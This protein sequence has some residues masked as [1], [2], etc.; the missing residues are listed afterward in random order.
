MFAA[1]VKTRFL[2]MYAAMFKGSRISKK[3]GPIFKILIALFAAYCIGALLF[4]LGMLFYGL[5]NPLCSAG[6][7][8]LYFTIE[9]IFCFALCFIG[10]VYATQ[11][12]IYNARD[13]ELL[14]S[15]PVPPAYIL[16]SRM[17]LL[18]ALNFIYGSLVAIPAGVVYIMQFGATVIGVLFYVLAFILLQFMA[19][20][21]S[22]LIGWLI[23]LITSKIRNKNLMTLVLSL[24]FFGA[25]FYLYSQ[26]QSY[27]ARL[28]ANGTAVAD[29]IQKAFPP[30]YYYGAAVANGD[31]L[32]LVIFALCALLPFALVYFVLSASFLKIATA[33]KT[34]LKKQ[35]R[36]KSAKQYSTGRALLRKELAHFFGSAMY[37]LNAGIGLVFMIAGAVF[38]LVKADS[39]PM[40][41]T[42]SEIPDG[43]ITSIMTLGICAIT[44]MVFISAPSVSLEG[45]NLWIARSIPVPASDILR[46]KVNLHF[47]VSLPPTIIASLCCLIVSHDTVIG[48]VMLVV[49]PIVLDW[50]FALLGV[51]INLKFPR[52]DWISE[53]AVVK[54]S[55]S[56]FVAMLASM[57]A[58]A[59]PIIVYLSLL[60]K[61]LTIDIF[62]LICCAVFAAVSIVLDRWIATRGAR[63]FESF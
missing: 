51:V 42:Q 25:Y 41:L 48:S 31:V 33:K 3:R 53:V 17:V 7:S 59:V 35:Y 28:V 43:I 18:F 57:A 1:L 61:Y 16:G 52:F 29:A 36:E 39:L 2:W 6:L 60:Y 4:M 62:M 44:S 21:V 13:N 12:Q 38:V 8:W 30:A 32:A 20:T 45:K 24:G 11:N 10:S 37:M 9:G 14:L 23:A 63:I 40:L 22:C 49:L 56:V 34:A 55:V 47:F 26:A 46:S 58:I 5:C 19:M 54:Q 15:M 50:M 27:I